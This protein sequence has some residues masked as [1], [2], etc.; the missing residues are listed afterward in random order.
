MLQRLTDDS[1]IKRL[2][3]TRQQL[4]AVSLRCGTAEQL[5]TVSQLFAAAA[6]SQEPELAQ[7][8]KAARQ[9][10]QQKTPDELTSCESH[11]PLLSAVS[12][13]FPAKSNVAVFKCQQALVG[14]GHAVR[15]TTEISQNLR[16]STKGRLGIDA[17]LA[18]PKTCEQPLKREGFG[19]VGYSAVK[20]EVVVLVSA[21]QG[22]QEEPAEQSGKDVD[23]Q[24]EAL[25][26]TA[27]VGAIKRESAARNNA[28]PLPIAHPRRFHRHFPDP[29]LNGPL[30]LVTATDVIIIT[31]VLCINSR[32]AATG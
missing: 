6:I 14:D 7:T 12:V 9:D 16:W 20:C 2:V 31:P 1:F 21:R 28:M 8:L 32:T 5:A 24:K 10:V 3:V 30:R 4:V 27:P 17:P 25:T 15:V 18:R 19:E 11:G 26:T 29:R 23:G 13:V 22:L